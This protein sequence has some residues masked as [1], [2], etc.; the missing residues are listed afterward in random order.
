ME[1]IV[2]I[3]DFFVGNLDA[4]LLIAAGI[5]AIT[6][7]EKDDSVFERVKNI[8]RKLNLLKPKQ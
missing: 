6:P 5:V 3:K 7:T 4:L 8:L 2:L 1:Y